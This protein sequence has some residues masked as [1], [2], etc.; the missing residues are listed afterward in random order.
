M[1]DTGRGCRP[2][3]ITSRRV[4]EKRNSALRSLQPRRR[5]R[6]DLKKCAVCNELRATARW[7]GM[8]SNFAKKSQE[9]KL[10]KELDFDYVKVVFT[11]SATGTRLGWAR[12]NG[13]F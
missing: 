5:E 13:C 10:D 12:S 4:S 8:G 6:L 7:V 1:A 2:L 11:E 3:V 9:K